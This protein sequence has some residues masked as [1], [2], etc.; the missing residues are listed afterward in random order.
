MEISHAVELFAVVQLL[1][2]VLLL[3]TPWAAVH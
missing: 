3:G 2:C 1:S